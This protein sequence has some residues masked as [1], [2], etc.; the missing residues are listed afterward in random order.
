MTTHERVHSMSVC[1]RQETKPLHRELWKFI[2]LRYG[3][4]L[5][6]KYIFSVA[7]SLRDLSK[8]CHFT[9]LFLTKQTSKATLTHRRIDV[10]NTANRGMSNI[11]QCY[12]K[13][14]GFPG[15]SVVNNPPAN[16]GDWGLIP[17]SW[18][19]HGKGNGN[20]P[21]YSGLGNPMDREAWWV[22]SM[23]SQKNGTWLRD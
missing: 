6:L 13:Y 5:F 2:S 7:G 11:R 16:A 17:G 9:F 10:C 15:A 14:K 20:P 21:Q 1:A 3:N 12:S 19:S 18:R 22:Q 23:G 8:Q 4:T